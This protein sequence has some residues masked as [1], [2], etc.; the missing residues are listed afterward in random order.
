LLFPA[1]NAQAFIPGEGSASKAGEGIEVTFS[2]NC[3]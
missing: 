1:K 2:L 3:I